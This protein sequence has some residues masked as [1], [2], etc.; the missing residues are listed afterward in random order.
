[1][2]DRDTSDRNRAD[3]RLAWTIGGALLL[4]SP[5]LSLGN[6]SIGSQIPAGGYIA[7]LCFA[8]ATVLFAFGIRGSGSV[9]ARRPLG[10][11][12]LVF[13]GVWTL[14]TATLLGG[15]LMSTLYTALGGVEWTLT[16]SYANVVIQFVGALIAV[17]Q[18]GRAGVVPRPWNWAPTWALAA[19]TVPWMILQIVGLVGGPAVVILAF[20]FSTIDGI[21]NIT[22]VMFLGV[23]AIVLAQVK[24][25]AEAATPSYDQGGEKATPVGADPGRRNRAVLLLLVVGGFVTVGGVVGGLVAK[26]S[27]DHALSVASGIRTLPVFTYAQYTQ[28]PPSLPGLM[29]LWIGS[30]V[31][32][33]G[34]VILLAGVVVAT[35]KPRLAS[36]L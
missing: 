36:Q 34:V 9:T 14:V 5:V 18:I 23:V 8:A 27:V 35:T 19:I 10:T 25:P 3:S 1:M 4:V 26:A 7:P 15:P 2:T 11:A 17:I 24:T 28:T 13:L 16:L 29:G 22:A 32:V 20:G 30:L 6:P 12:A 33:L 21:V 31:A